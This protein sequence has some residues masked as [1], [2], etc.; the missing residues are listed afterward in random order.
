MIQLLSVLNLD[1]DV[2]KKIG[3]LMNPI[4]NLNNVQKKYTLY[5]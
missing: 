5:N 2:F 3:R 1:H 4:F